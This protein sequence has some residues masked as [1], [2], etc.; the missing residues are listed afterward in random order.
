VSVVCRLTRVGC[1]V[2]VA[3]DHHGA[4]M[5]PSLS[6]RVSR[7]GMRLDTDSG[8]N[9]M[10]NMYLQ[11]RVWFTIGYVCQVYVVS[12]R[13]QCP[14]THIVLLY[15]CTHIVLL[16]VCTHIVAPMRANG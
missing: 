15:V 8:K 1:L 10:A 13:V 11:V 12:A 3:C 7:D 6:H 4:F 14:C 5:W 2:L 9:V 16:Y